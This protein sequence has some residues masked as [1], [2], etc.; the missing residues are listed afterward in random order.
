VPRSEAEGLARGIHAAMEASPG[1]N[2]NLMAYAL[3]TR[4][5]SGFALPL[6]AK[7]F[8]RKQAAFSRRITRL[9]GS[10]TT[11]CERPGKARMNAR[12]D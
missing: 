11:D 10:V 4:R 12:M 9:Q 5:S 7:A 8:T 3:Q 1:R 2:G 6:R